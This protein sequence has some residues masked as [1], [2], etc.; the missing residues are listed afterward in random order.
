ARQRRPARGGP[1]VDSGRG[2]GPDQQ[3]LR[4]AGPEDHAGALRGLW[5]AAG[6]RRCG[7]RADV[8]PTGEHGPQAARRPRGHFAKIALGIITWTPLLRSTSSVTSTSPATLTS[9]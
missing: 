1:D 9:M 7:R 4:Q 8:R 5:R 6:D 2:C 3:L